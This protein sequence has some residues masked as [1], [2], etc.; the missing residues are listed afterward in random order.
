MKQIIK[1]WPRGAKVTAP[2]SGRHS[3][4]SASP[5]KIGSMLKLFVNGR[6]LNRFEAELYYDHCL[7]STVSKLQDWG[8]KV[9]RQ[10]EQVPCLGAREQV[11]V[12]RYWLRCDPDNLQLARK[13][14]SAWEGRSYARVPKEGGTPYG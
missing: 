1:K 8:L 13:L 14:L 4:D 12:K 7:H 6:S 9:D 2:Q 10:W 5:T 3:H 11:R